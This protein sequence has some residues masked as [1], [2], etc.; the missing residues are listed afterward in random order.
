MSSKAK[1]NFFERV[2][3]FSASNINKKKMRL[4]GT[5]GTIL[6]KGQNNNGSWEYEVSVDNDKGYV[7]SFD[8]H[9][10]ESLGEFMSKEEFYGEEPTVV[11]VVVAPNKKGELV[12]KLKAGY[13]DFKKK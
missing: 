8:E 5:L 11:K 3:I 4:D 9:E 12:G 6:A 10:L 13:G 7:C 2:R 1:F